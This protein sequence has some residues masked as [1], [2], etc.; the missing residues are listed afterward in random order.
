[1]LLWPW[2][3]ILCIYHLDLVLRDC[4][5]HLH[6]DASVNLIEQVVNVIRFERSRVEIKLKYIWNLRL[7]RIG[8]EMINRLEKYGL[9]GLLT[10]ELYLICV[11]S[12]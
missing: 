2:V 12:L 1:M 7:G 11:S 8:E 9:M 4:L 3:S 6:G 5:Y 10:V